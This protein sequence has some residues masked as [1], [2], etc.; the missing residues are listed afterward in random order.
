MISLPTSAGVRVRVTLAAAVVGLLGAIA[1]SVLFIG[2]LHESLEESLLSQAQQDSATVRAQLAAGGTLREA[3]TSDGG[4]I[5][6]QVL[7]AQGRIV[8]SDHPD[9]TRALRTSPGRSRGVSARPLD[10]RFAVYARSTPSGR[11]IVVGVSQEQVERATT[12]AVVLLLIGVPLGIALLAVVV[13]LAIGRALRPVEVMRREADM[14]TSAHL[15]RRLAVPPGEDEIP[16]LAS[17]LNEMLDRI[18][19]AQ[20][21]QR[22][23]VSDAS[24]ELRSPLTSLRQVAEV[25]LRHPDA[26]SV[27]D[28]AGTVFAEEQRMETLV[29]AL[30]MLARL[31][32]GGSARPGVVD[33]DDAVLRE[34]QRLRAAS[35]GLTFDIAGVSAG[36]VHGEAVLLGQVVTNLLSN[37]ARHAAS[38][39]VVGLSEVGERVVFTVDD[40]GSGIPPEDRERV[41]ERFVRLD[42]ARARDSGGT[43]LGLAIVRKV[44]DAGNGTVRVEESRLGGARFVVELP[45]S[46]P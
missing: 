10:D 34:V 17:T 26:T 1:G 4:D 41:F 13:W 37:A 30:L 21:Q 35:P 24:H 6:I 12:T 46:R 43:G 19:R 38:R 32:D 11:L 20:S 31:D 40:D 25:A 3:T 16:L 39:V 44:V 42:E 5:V 18:D 9:V 2:V 8:G 27:R 29:Q 33:L 22:Q 36:Q 23:F 45:A 15:H 7:D 14:I 28:V